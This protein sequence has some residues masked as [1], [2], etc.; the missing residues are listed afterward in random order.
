MHSLS[1]EVAHFEG[2]LRDQWLEVLKQQTL[3]G[4]LKDQWLEVL[5][6]RGSLKD[7]WLEVLK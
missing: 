1:P 2:R 6:L 7:Q 3:R 4:S 5:T